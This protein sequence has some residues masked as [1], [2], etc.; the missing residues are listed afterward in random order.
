MLQRIWGHAWPL[1][2]IFTWLLHD[3]MHCAADRERNALRDVYRE[4]AKVRA[5][6]RVKSR[7]K[8]IAAATGVISFWHAVH[9]Q[10]E[11]LGAGDGAPHDRLSQSEALADDHASH[12]PSDPTATPTPVAQFTPQPQ[13]QA[14]HGEGELLAD[15]SRPIS[16]LLVDCEEVESLARL[17]PRV[18]ALE[19]RLQGILH[20]M[21]DE[22]GYDS[23][24]GIGL[25]P[26]LSFLR[27][28]KILGPLVDLHAAQ[29][30]F[31]QHATM[32]RLSA[33]LLQARRYVDRWRLRSWTLDGHG[34]DAFER[35]QPDTTLDLSGAQLRKVLQ[36]ADFEVPLVEVDDFV[37]RWQQAPEGL[38]WGVVTEWLEERHM[39]RA[40]LE[41][42]QASARKVQ[43]SAAQRQSSHR[44]PASV[45]QCRW[46]A[47]SESGFTA[48]LGDVARL[49]DMALEHKH[50]P[51]GPVT[52][53]GSPS[54]RHS[55]RNLARTMSG[56][57]RSLVSQPNA[58]Q[59][60]L[61]MQ[62]LMSRFVWP[63]IRSYILRQKT[64][65]HTSIGRQ[66]ANPIMV[67]EWLSGNSDAV[68]ECVQK[69][70]CTP[71]P[72]KFVLEATTKTI[73]SFWPAS[74]VTASV[75][76]T[77]DGSTEGTA[78]GE[79][80]NSGRHQQDS[81]VSGPFA[82]TGQR[83]SI[84]AM[85]NPS[86]DVDAQTVKVLQRRSSRAELM[87]APMPP[88]R[89]RAGRSRS[90]F[91]R[92]TQLSTARGG[93]GAAGTAGL[94]RRLSAAVHSGPAPTLR[95]PDIFGPWLR[96]G[97]KFSPTAGAAEDQTSPTSRSA[98]SI[99]AVSEDQ[100][101][102]VH[103][104]AAMLYHTDLYPTVLGCSAMDGFEVLSTIMACMSGM[105]SA[106]ECL[107]DAD[108]FSLLRRV[109]P[110]TQ[111]GVGQGRTNRLG[112]RDSVSHRRRFHV[113]QERNTDGRLV[114]LPTGQTE[115]KNPWLQTTVPQVDGY[116][117]R[118]LA[119]HEMRRS[120]AS[121]GTLDFYLSTLRKEFFAWR[122]FDIFGRMAVH[123]PDAPVKST[124]DELFRF[125][126]QSGVRCAG[127][128]LS[129][130]LHRIVELSE[131]KKLERLHAVKTQGTKAVQLQGNGLVEKPDVAALTVAA[132][133]ASLSQIMTSMVLES[134]DGT[135]DE[136]GATT[137]NG[138]G[139]DT[140][141]LKSKRGGERKA[142][143]GD[144]QGGLPSD[145]DGP[146]FDDML[147][148]AASSHVMFT[149]AELVLVLREAARMQRLC[150]A[151]FLSKTE[152]LFFLGSVGQIVFEAPKYRTLLPPSCRS[153]T[154][155]TYFI[156]HM[157][158]KPLRRKF[159]IQASA[160][161]AGRRNSSLSGQDNAL[162]AIFALT[163]AESLHSRS[164]S[165]NNS[166]QVGFGN[167]PSVQAISVDLNADGIETSPVCPA[168]LDLLAFARGICRDYQYLGNAA[169]QRDM[170]FDLFVLFLNDC[171]S[172]FR[173]LPPM[174]VFSTFC[175][176]A[177][178]G[179][180]A[181]RARR[182]S[183]VSAVVPSAAEQGFGLQNQQDREQDSSKLHDIGDIRALFAEKLEQIILRGVLSEESFGFV[184]LSLV[185]QTFMI[186]L[187]NPNY[188][189][190]S[191]HDDDFTKPLAQDGTSI[192]SLC[193]TAAKR[194]LAAMFSCYRPF[195]HYAKTAAVSLQHLQAERNVRQ[196][197]Q[198]YTVMQAV[199][200]AAFQH[201]DRADLP[202][203][204]PDRF[205]GTAAQH[206]LPN[207]LMKVIHGFRRT[208]VHSWVE[209]C[210][211]QGLHLTNVSATRML[212][213][214]IETHLSL[215]IGS[216]RYAA[217]DLQ[218]MASRSGG[219][220]LMRMRRV[221][222]YHEWR[223]AD[224]AQPADESNASDDDSDDSDGDEG[225]VST[226]GRSRAHASYRRAP[227]GTKAR[228]SRETRSHANPRQLIYPAVRL[229]SGSVCFVHLPRVQLKTGYL[230][231]PCFFR[232]MTMAVLHQHFDDAHDR[233]FGIQ[234]NSLNEGV[235]PNM[236]RAVEAV[237][238]SHNVV[239]LGKHW[240]SLQ[241]MLNEHVELA[242]TAAV[243]GARSASGSSADVSLCLETVL[244][245]SLAEMDPTAELR[246]ALE[247]EVAT[248]TNPAA[249]GT[250][251]SQHGLQQ[252]W[253]RRVK[254][255]LQVQRWKA[256]A[257]QV[258]AG[259]ESS[260]TY[261]AVQHVF[262][263]QLAR[264][265]SERFV[266]QLMACTCPLNSKYV[267]D[268]CVCSVC[269][270]R[271][272]TLATPSASTA[273]APRCVNCIA[274]ARRG[275][276]GVYKSFDHTGHHPP[277]MPQ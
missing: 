198:P 27:D 93:Q 253:Q 44:H 176:F 64:G 123:F 37:T 65:L 272:R 231:R 251:Q 275:R 7:W 224:S 249:E 264:P 89:S 179:Y 143:R 166:S 165:A 154:R 196:G 41:A 259:A 228:S 185:Y 271:T 124:V 23:W 78:G 219:R 82:L 97:H 232:F 133:F 104:L 90:E 159:G 212:E 243:N 39:D 110:S 235:P 118:L 140:S 240:S 91:Q 160:T 188:H 46:S 24:S 214:I 92:P 192:E 106:S 237:A 51:A 112:G 203:F 138:S 113:H 87:H 260:G 57:S 273:R 115:A 145:P 122:P 98:F 244:A 141:K 208:T 150:D 247:A 33:Q 34:F 105:L 85:F 226:F 71:L 137:Q 161:R 70:G 155:Y 6:L 172:I 96:A 125:L 178:F 246:Q 17:A 13:V 58:Q 16:E 169:E 266:E 128:V 241:R 142:P 68:L 45:E 258:T 171:G 239:T 11:A 19:Q 209:N 174:Q 121:A 60:R 109:G 139:K 73:S 177:S 129:Y 218:W 95:I 81:N 42:M 211:L 227:T 94:H 207:A 4:V 28:A 210:V 144:R 54:R 265:T 79:M 175:F 84:E 119:W 127:M 255:S 116:T 15:P 36:A 114:H 88:P 204:R 38:Q 56:S 202:G 3:Q 151:T 270:D 268:R 43:P 47:L 40:T 194:Q 52:P 261:A 220:D 162:T 35:V 180:E 55:S 215:V 197:R 99:D 152:V 184:V 108:P 77:A 69:L 21:V 62:T 216:A 111:S 263:A 242:K 83:F 25:G 101:L 29:Q 221:A 157:L 256:A 182:L 14:Q 191:F 132:P 134:T 32:H 53:R 100:F 131:H 22:V 9:K 146:V 117:D 248:E 103:H 186:Q 5:K 225:M 10:R 59:Q 187:Q 267:Y 156:T 12:T 274:C 149:F 223:K 30:I 163:N 195:D 229:E 250:V 167:H 222:I 193:Y 74:C 254:S 158:R 170:N 190:E 49:V 277:L 2:R 80:G 1:S 102:S 213:A 63:T 147:Q 120:G 130:V 61:L 173:Q 18:V 236:L 48:A 153:V 205:D 200:N 262:S 76:E 206:P 230:V 50:R 276:M 252:L 135:A 136:A 233:N 86:E 75:Q 245:K 26:W 269:V 217:P 148:Q 183:L 257:M 168:A 107:C 234:L 67:E 181:S 238:R 126:Q 66:L 20:V 164:E 72:R 8:R 201:G 189:M 31:A 199:P